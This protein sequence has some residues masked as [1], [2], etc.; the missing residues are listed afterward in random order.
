LATIVGRRRAD[1]FLFESE[2]AGA[3][4]RFDVVVG[5]SAVLD[6][7][8]VGDVATGIAAGL[9]GEIRDIAAFLDALR[10]ADAREAEDGNHG[11][12]QETLDVHSKHSSGTGFLLF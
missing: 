5:T 10:E 1:G 11:L 7:Q 6:E 4:R 2:D 12:G 9:G 8:F 3:G